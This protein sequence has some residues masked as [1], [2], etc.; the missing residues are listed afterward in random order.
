MKRKNNEIKNVPA[1]WAAKIKRESFRQVFSGIV[2]CHFSL[3]STLFSWP[4]SQRSFLSDA[5]LEGSRWRALG[6]SRF[7]RD[8]NL[9][10]FPCQTICCQ[11]LPPFI[12]HLPSKV[13]SWVV[14]Y[15]SHVWD[16]KS[17][18]ES[19]ICTIPFH[20]YRFTLFR[21]VRLL[22]CT[23]NSAFKVQLRSTTSRTK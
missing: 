13:F 20:D 14:H 10:F 11:L 8:R 21:A 6:S 15:C 12:R 19:W 23:H 17:C 2:S 7:K 18:L 5:P 22:H 9:F 1:T 3:D 16:N 4:S